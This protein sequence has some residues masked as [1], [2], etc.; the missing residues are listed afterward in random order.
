LDN[1]GFVEPVEFGSS[2]QWLVKPDGPIRAA[3]SAPNF[4]AACHAP[5]AAR[6]ASCWSFVL[7]VTH[8]RYRSPDE[9][10]ARQRLAFS[11]ARF[12][13]SSLKRRS[14]AGPRAGK[15]LRTLEIGFRHDRIFAGKV[16][17]I[18]RDDTPAAE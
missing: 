2:I 5:N 3:R 16:Y 15:S 17:R 1:P 10:I 4:S 12:A 7:V 11:S 6:K 18:P 8:Q 14:P 13:F 9:W